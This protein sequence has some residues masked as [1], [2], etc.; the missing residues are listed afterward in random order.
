MIPAWS[1]PMPTSSSARII[2]L[3]LD[4][5]Q[6]RLA[7][8]RSRRAS[9]RRAAPPPRS[10]RPPRSARRRRS[11][12]ARRRRRRPCRRVSRSASG[13]CS[14]S[15]TRPVTKRGGSPT[16]TRCSRSSL[17]PAIVSRSASLPARAAPGSQYDAQPGERDPH[18]PAPNCS[19]RRRSLS[20]S[21]AQVG[22]LVDE[23]RDALDA[24][25]PREA[26]H[27]L[28]VV[29]AAGHVVEHVRVDHPRA[30]DLDPALALAEWSSALSPRSRCRRSGSRRRRPRRS[31]R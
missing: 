13:C 17:S 31:A 7:E 3:G 8:R 5:A 1:S 18:A 24:H 15:S 28:L 21:I 22:H 23:H 10:G 25:A 6:L 20:K 11:S 2:P 12:A 14:A 4:P 26:L 29:A 27:A 19:S 9:P 16:P 30:E